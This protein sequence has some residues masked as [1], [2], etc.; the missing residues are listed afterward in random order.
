MLCY[1][2]MRCLI[3]TYDGEKLEKIFEISNFKVWPGDVVF[4]DFTNPMAYDY[5]TQMTKAFH[6]QVQFD[7][8]W[9]VSF[10]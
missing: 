8:I 5:W 10:T 4:P 2:N 7:G 1:N 3:N 6:D 9:I